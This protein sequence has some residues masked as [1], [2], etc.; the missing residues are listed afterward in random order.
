MVDYGSGETICINPLFSNHFG[1]VRKNFIDWRIRAIGAGIKVGS[2]VRLKSG[3]RSLTNGKVITGLGSDRS[4]LK[5]FDYRYANNFDA[6]GFYTNPESVTQCPGFPAQA[7]TIF[8]QI[9]EGIF[10]L[11]SLDI[12]RT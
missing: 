10:P 1:V 8:V 11:S 7:T 9:A 2:L 3:R 5:V 4:V 6:Q 12:I